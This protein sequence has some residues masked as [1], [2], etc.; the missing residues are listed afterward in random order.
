MKRIFA[1]AAMLC[2]LLPL[3]AGC[4]DATLPD[5]GMSAKDIMKGAIS[6]GNTYGYTLKVTGFE[7][8]TET[9]G[10][11]NT[12][13]YSY[14][15]NDYLY[16]YIESSSYYGDAIYIGLDEVAFDAGDYDT[17]TNEWVSLVYGVME[18]ID[19]KADTD[20]FD[21]IFSAADI[22]TYHGYTY[23]YEEYNGMYYVI[24]TK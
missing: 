14:T 15:I 17:P 2:M 23:T 19:P 6:N 3:L 16:L 8:N 11:V 1:F 20:E 21:T 10:G 18:T 24:I 22:V 4:G 9:S 12:T 7:S 5:F 13:D